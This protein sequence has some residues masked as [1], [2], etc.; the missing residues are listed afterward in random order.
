M[1]TEETIGGW[2]GG[3]ET[4]Y[5]E[6]LSTDAYSDYTLSLQL[7]LPKTQ[8]K[9]RKTC[10]ICFVFVSPFLLIG[11]ILLLNVTVTGLLNK[12]RNDTADEVFNRASTTPKGDVHSK[13]TKMGPTAR[14]SRKKKSEYRRSVN[15][16]NILLGENFYRKNF[17]I[18]LFQRCCSLIYFN[19]VILLIRNFNCCVDVY[20][21]T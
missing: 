3:E 17:K 19:L 12:I 10:N 5:T 11:L 6:T 16:V 13:T 18:I 14:K 9:R 4:R 21:Q 7:P 2:H 8:S 1:T 15:R 20:T